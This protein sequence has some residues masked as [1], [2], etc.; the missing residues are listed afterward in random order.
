[1]AGRPVAGRSGGG[2]GLLYGLIAFAILTVVFLVLFVLMFTRVQAAEDAA[3]RAEAQRQQWGNPPAWYAT[4]AGNRRTPVF[5]LMNSEIEELGSIVAGVPDTISPQVRD[6][7]RDT[8][9]AAAAA[10]GGL[11]QP[12]DSLTSAIQKLVTALNSERSARANMDQKLE[13]AVADVSDLANQ[14]QALRSEFEAQVAAFNEK[15]SQVE[16]TRDETLGQKDEQVASLTEQ[17]DASAQ[18]VNELRRLSQTQQRDAEFALARAERRLSDL[19]SS[20]RALKPNQF[21]RDAILKKSD[22]RVL[23]SIPGSDVIYV[24]LGARDNVK[25][26]MGLEVYSRT[27]EQRDTVRGKASCEIVSVSD[28]VAECRVTRRTPGSPILEGDVVLNIAFER[29]R[30]PKFAV[31]GDFDLNYDGSI[32]PQGRESIENMIRQWGGQVVDELDEGTDYVV[33]GLAPDIPVAPSGELTD[34]VR[35]QQFQRGLDASR[36]ADIV[37]RANE[38]GVPVITQNQFLFL[39]GYAGDAPVTIQSSR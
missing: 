10:T 37:R 9:N 7:A 30:K 28:S 32:D 18:E 36:F 22:G 34:V 20:I 38:L 4:E 27:G 16:S 19:Q 39:S 25:V 2:S 14:T 33:I 8:I 15:L 17:L 3:R 13:Q 23:R 26:G 5:Q 11:V 29:G 35:D 6:L 31:R 24:N 1:M 12:G 21:Q